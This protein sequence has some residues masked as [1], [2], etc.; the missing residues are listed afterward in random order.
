MNAKRYIATYA[1]N[2]NLILTCYSNICSPPDM[3]ISAGQCK[4]IYCSYY[5]RIFQFKHLLCCL[6]SIVSKILAHVI[7]NYFIFHFIQIKK[8]SHHFRNLGCNL[9]TVIQ[10]NLP[11]S[12]LWWYALPFYLYQLQTGH[13]SLFSVLWSPKVYFL[14]AS[15]VTGTH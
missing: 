1:S 8:T 7:L 13:S 14:G 11:C 12:Q 5:N 2:I 3:F 15:V 6:C 4:T 10:S 9:K